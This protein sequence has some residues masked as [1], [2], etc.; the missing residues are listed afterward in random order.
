M[1]NENLAQVVAQ[2]VGDWRRGDAHGVGHGKDVKRSVAIKV[3]EVFL[4][5]R[6]YPMLHHPFHQVGIGWEPITSAA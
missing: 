6:F 3:L 1:V 5:I 2:L 4:P